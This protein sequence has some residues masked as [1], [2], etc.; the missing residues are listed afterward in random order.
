M[1]AAGYGITPLS[2]SRRGPGLALGGRRL[3]AVVA[4]VAAG[5]LLAEVAHGGA[6]PAGSKVVVEPGD[7]LW[8]I[9]AERYP[10]DDVRARVVEIETL[11]GL[12]GPVIQAGET[13]QLP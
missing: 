1:Y 6:V 12:S 4:A 10:G 11:N 5:I 7:T 13:L 2:A 3:A 8:A 9:A